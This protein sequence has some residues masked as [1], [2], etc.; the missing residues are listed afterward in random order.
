MKPA[1]RKGPTNMPMRCTP[2][3]VDMARARRCSGAT[4]IRKV[5][6]AS[7]NTARA[8]PTMKTASPNSQTL[9]ATMQSSSASS[10]KTEAPIIARRSP[11]RVVSWAA[12]RLASSE[13]RPTRATI[14]PATAE[15]APSAR[16]LSASTGRMAPS[17]RPNMSEGPNA[18]SASRRRSKLSGA[19]GMGTPQL[20]AQAAEAAGG[21]GDG[22]DRAS[23]DAP[24]AGWSPAS[25][26][27]ALARFRQLL[28]QRLDALLHRGDAAV[29]RADVEVGDVLGRRIQAIAIAQPGGV[30]HPHVAEAELLQHAGG[31]A[32]ARAGLAIDD[33]LLVRIEPGV[34]RLQRLVVLERH[35]AVVAHLLAGEFQQRRRIVPVHLVRDVDGAGHMAAAQRADVGAGEFPGR[36]R[37]DDLHIVPAEALKDLLR[38][39]GHRGIRLELQRDRRCLGGSGLHG[40][41][42]GLPALDALVID[43]Y[44][45]GAE[46]AQREPAEVRLPCA[47]GA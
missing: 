37:I 40:Q 8:S 9:F 7:M 4:S 3:S 17:H 19:E 36:A 45:V 43:A 26:S 27:V 35:A 14:S 41:A 47:A 1:P 31:L 11:K 13:P 5:W 29:E 10:A 21:A 44:P 18:G 42:F 38:G 34:E 33:R 23:P 28:L 32:R 30:V 20:S 2:P 25:E 6:R 15:L 46:V 39:D 22:Q 12:G 16:A 24:R